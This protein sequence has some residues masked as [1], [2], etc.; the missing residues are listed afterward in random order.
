[1]AGALGMSWK[2]FLSFDVLAGL[3]WTVAFLAIGALFSAEIELV[4]DV[5]TEFGTIAGVAIAIVLAVMLTARWLRRRWMRSER[6]A[7]RVSVDEL[8]EM[9]RRGRD[10]VVIDVRSAIAVMQD[11]RRVPGAVAVTLADLPSHASR[12]PR[13]REIVLYCTC[14]NEISALRGARLLHDQGLHRARALTGGLDA[15]IETEEP[16][17]PMPTEGELSAT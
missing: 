1:M 4:L 6:Y 16:S 15:W 14:P 11:E 5:M 8:R 3:I 17:P 10:P 7:P 12:L 2:R 9:I 13:D